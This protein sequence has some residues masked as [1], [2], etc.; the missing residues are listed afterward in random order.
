ML[1]R[2]KVIFFSLLL[3]IAKEGVG[4]A[5][6]NDVRRS[7]EGSWLLLEQHSDSLFLTRNLRGNLTLGQKFELNWDGTFWDINSA[8]CGNDPNIHRYEGSWKLDTAKMIL[9]TTFQGSAKINFYKIIE[10]TEYDLVLVR[11]G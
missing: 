2:F 11:V 5:S 1:K 7:L 3:V 10:L 4:Q 9:T 6:N 8:G